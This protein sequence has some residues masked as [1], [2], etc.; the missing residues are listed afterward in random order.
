MSLT[1]KGYAIRASLRVECQIRDDLGSTDI[2]VAAI[3]VLAIAAHPHMEVAA[4][5]FRAAA[6]ESC[7]SIKRSA[8]TYGCYRQE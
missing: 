1:I 2:C 3:V 7:G 4:L 8:K 6:S 5:I